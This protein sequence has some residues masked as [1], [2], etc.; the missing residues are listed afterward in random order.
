[1][2]WQAWA[3]LTA[4]TSAVGVLA[5]CTWPSSLDTRAPLTPADVEQRMQHIGA[6]GVVWELNRDGKWGQVI[7][8]IA[9]GRSDW[10]KIVL[11]LSQ[12]TD[13]G[14]SEELRD[15][16]GLALPLNAP[17]VLGSLDPKNGVVSGVDSVCSMP[18]GYNAFQS[19]PADFTERA[20]RT[21]EA[22]HTPAL[23]RVRDRCLSVLHAGVC[24]VCPGGRLAR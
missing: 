22:V 14:W 6:R 13:A 24:L 1:M 11:Q 17:G 23:A 2:R 15:N 7:N 16:L 20:I 5:W 10:L 19:L 9:S 8:G 21:V 18:F 3:V 12:G 4:L